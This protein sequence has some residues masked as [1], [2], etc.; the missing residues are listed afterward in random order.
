MIRQVAIGL[1]VV[2]HNALTLNILLFF[3]F[4]LN[5]IVVVVWIKSI[6]LRQ[7]SHLYSFCMGLV[8]GLVGVG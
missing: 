6:D 5:C 8:V 3:S 1:L 4:T 2:Y 7:L